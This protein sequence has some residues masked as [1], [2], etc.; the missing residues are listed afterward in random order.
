MPI[1]VVHRRAQP[2]ERKDLRDARDGTGH[3]A[4]EGLLHGRRQD[5]A[6]KLRVDAGLE[7]WRVAASYSERGVL[8][9]CEV[10][11]VPPQRR[12]SG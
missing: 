3:A 5:L 7:R 4:L 9:W 8:H 2:H 10:L 6:C 1:L 11:V 12:G